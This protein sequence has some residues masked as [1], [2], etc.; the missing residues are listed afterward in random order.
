MLWHSFFLFRR[1]TKVEGCRQ[2]RRHATSPIYSTKKECQSIL[3]FVPKRDKGRGLSAE[4]TA[5]HESHLLHIK[6]RMLWH[7]FFVPNKNPYGSCGAFGSNISKSGVN[8]GHDCRLRQWSA[9]HGRAVAASSC[10]IVCCRRP[11]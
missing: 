9:R 2:G 7:S 4:P 3:F 5:C 8:R 6:K 10:H 11:R 1:E